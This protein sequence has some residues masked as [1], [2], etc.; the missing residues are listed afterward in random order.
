MGRRS[1]GDLVDISCLL[2]GQRRCD[3][4]DL[5]VLN[6]GSV[7]PRVAAS[8]GRGP[9]SGPRKGRRGEK[10]KELHLQ[11]LWSSVI[12]RSLECSLL[13]C[14]FSVA[15]NSLRPSAE[16]PRQHE[17]MPTMASSSPSAEPWPA[18]F[19]FLPFWSKAG[20]E[21][22]ETTPSNKPLV[23]LVRPNNDRHLPQ[24]R[25]TQTKH[26]PPTCTTLCIFEYF[27]ASWLRR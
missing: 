24:Q 23:L 10:E 6:K 18:L 16:P 13:P 4:Y 25:N 20:Q 22:K 27:T 15:V 12:C 17:M 2:A 7:R 5:S 8:T 9:G 19:S 26:F 11:Y 14:V 3:G 1:L 21:D